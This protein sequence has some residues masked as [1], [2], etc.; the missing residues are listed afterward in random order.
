MAAK[1][2]VLIGWNHGKDSDPLHF[3]DSFI[4]GSSQEGAQK[5]SLQT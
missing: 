5:D 1:Q 4:V 3:K 2:G